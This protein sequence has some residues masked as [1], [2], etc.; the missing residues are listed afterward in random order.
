MALNAAT[1]SSGIQTK[2]SEKNAALAS[3][4][5]DLVYLADSIAEAVVEHILA[6][7]VVTVT[8]ASAYGRRVGGNRH[9]DHYVGHAPLSSPASL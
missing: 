9:W 8:T 6:N 2:L 4:G 5:I 7:A 1:L 3:A